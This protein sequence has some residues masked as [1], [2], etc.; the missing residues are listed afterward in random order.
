MSMTGFRLMD[1]V[2]ILYHRLK[3]TST[4]ADIPIS[5]DACLTCPDWLMGF[6]MDY[7]LWLHLSPLYLLFLGWRQKQQSTMPSVMTFYLLVPWCLCLAAA[8][9][10]SVLFHNLCDVYTVY[11]VIPLSL[12]L[13][14]AVSLSPSLCL[15]FSACLYLQAADAFL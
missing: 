5:V 3:R 8:S 6:W 1:F 14:V 13:S 15:S 2:H 9:C 10:G 4:F 7:K 11:I 12:S